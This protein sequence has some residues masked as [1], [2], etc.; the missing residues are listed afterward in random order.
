MVSRSDILHGQYLEHSWL[1]WARSAFFSC[2]R[3][4]V[5]VCICVQVGICSWMLLPTSCAIQTVTRTTSAAHCCTCLRRRT[6]R[7]SRS[8][9]LASCWSGWLL[10]DLIRGVFSSPS[11]NSSRTHSSSSGIMSLSTVHQKSKSMSCF[12]VIIHCYNTV[13]LAALK[14]SGPVRNYG[15][16]W[17]K[18]GVTVYWKIRQLNKDKSKF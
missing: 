3:L 8:R 15:N 14:A 11:L 7:P 10:T 9:S 1:H 5:Y 4:S 13:G 16:C 12:G 6:Q 17:S 2:C 18:P